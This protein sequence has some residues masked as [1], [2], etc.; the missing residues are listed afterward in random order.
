[1]FCDNSENVLGAE[2][3]EGVV[4]HGLVEEVPV[5]VLLDTGS[6]RILVRKEL[7]PEGKVL[8]GRM[9]G[10]RCAH[11]EVV[12]YPI[13]ELEVAVGRHEDPHQSR[14]IGSTPCTVDD[15][16]HRQWEPKGSESTHDTIH[17]LVLP[18]KYQD[19]ALAI[20]HEIPLGG[21]LG[22]TKTAQCLLQQFYWPTLHADVANFCRACKAC[23]LDSP[24]RACSS[25]IYLGGVRL[26]P[27]TPQPWH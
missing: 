1:M 2:V 16:L 25:V 12:H 20:A 4:R 21:H 18:A 23:Q 17:Q 19:T 24:R 13:A 6:V 5:E 22:K 14:G 27:A 3:G 10:V 7:V 15:L 26:P 8:E 9:V 11:G